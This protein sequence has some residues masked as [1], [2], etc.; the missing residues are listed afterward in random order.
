M[1]G[2]AS[3]HCQPKWTRRALSAREAAHRLLWCVLM[4]ALCDVVARVARHI[5]L[6]AWRPGSLMQVVFGGA[7]NIGNYGSVPGMT[8]V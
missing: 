3:C 8:R 4:N 6:T 7:G 1:H 5:M 2:H